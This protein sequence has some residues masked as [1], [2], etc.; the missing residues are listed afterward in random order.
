MPAADALP[1][2]EPALLVAPA[3]A[4]LLAERR[5]A[6]TAHGSAEAAPGADV[7]PQL[8]VADVLALAISA[9]VVVAHFALV[10]LAAL[11]CAV[12]RAAPASAVELPHVVA[13]ATESSVVAPRHVAL[14]VVDA[15]IVFDPADEAVDL[16]VGLAPG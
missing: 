12:A 8:Q 3:A 10:V 6:Q 13:V 16:P 15:P 9:S 5:V 11:D 2:A 4:A 14:A 1:V 7:A